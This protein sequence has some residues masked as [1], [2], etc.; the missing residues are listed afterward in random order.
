MPRGGR[1]QRIM[2]SETCAAEHKTC[3]RTKCDRNVNN[4]G[5]NAGKVVLLVRHLAQYKA[6]F[7]DIKVAFN[8][9]L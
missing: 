5:K 9:R 3:Q 7:R 1:E 6:I 8:G 4:R 2:A